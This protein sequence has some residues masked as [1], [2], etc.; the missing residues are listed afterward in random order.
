MMS[1]TP[2]AIG[3]TVDLEET[4]PPSEHIG[5]CLILLEGCHQDCMCGTIGGASNKSRRSWSNYVIG[6][7]LGGN[8]PPSANRAKELALK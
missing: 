8:R 7:S 6:A 5:N 3:R 2:A 1:C 4:F